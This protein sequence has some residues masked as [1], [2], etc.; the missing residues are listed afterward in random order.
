MAAGVERPGERGTPLV[1]DAPLWW[2]WKKGFYWA[3]VQANYAALSAVVETKVGGQQVPP[4]P[5]CHTA[6]YNCSASG[7]RVPA[8]PWMTPAACS[9]LLHLWLLTWEGWL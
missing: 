9:S 1:G 5:A 4:P 7:E 2:H 8:C 6:T 3:L